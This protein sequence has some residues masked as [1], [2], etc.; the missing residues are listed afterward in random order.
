MLINS[1][2]VAQA[3]SRQVAL[4][5]SR[6]AAA[7][8]SLRPDGFG[9]DAVVRER[10]QVGLA[11][12]AGWKS[13][14]WSGGDS[15]AAGYLP[16][17]LAGSPAQAGPFKASFAMKSAVQNSTDPHNNIQVTR[18]VPASRGGVGPHPVREPGPA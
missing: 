6:R 17:Q 10:G 3:P 18:L 9:L 13:G 8:G 16:G 14:I 1:E 2:C 15:A 11:V 5:P 12:E 7:A 4:A